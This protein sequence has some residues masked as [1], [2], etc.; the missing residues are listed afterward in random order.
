MLFRSL[1][2]LRDG[3]ETRFVILFPQGRDEIVGDTNSES[4]SSLNGQNYRNSSV[5]NDP[6]TTHMHVGSH[7]MCTVTGDLLFGA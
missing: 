4:L 1:I 6:Q 2:I 7:A 3:Y 5:S